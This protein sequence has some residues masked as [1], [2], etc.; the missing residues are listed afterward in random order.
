MHG[1]ETP[2]VVPARNHVRPDARSSPVSDARYLRLN[3][4]SLRRARDHNS[5]RTLFELG[6]ADQEHFRQIAQ[7]QLVPESPEDHECDDVGR[8]LSAVQDS[9]AALI[10][11]F[12]TDPAPEPPVTLRR[13]LWPF[14]SRVAL[15]S[16]PK[17]N[18][19]FVS[20]F[21]PPAHQASNGTR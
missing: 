9:A 15:A 11:L 1:L 5:R 20:R 3:A 10:E 12:A 14:G 19:G 16:A 18:R 2:L 4:R 7:T 13:P 17:P 6:P 8:V 21:S